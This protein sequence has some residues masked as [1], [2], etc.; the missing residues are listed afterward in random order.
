MP[1][2]YYATA[3]AYYARIYA[4]C[5]GVPIMY[6]GIIAACLCM[7]LEYTGAI[8]IAIALVYSKAHTACRWRGLTN[9]TLIEPLCSISY[10]ANHPIS[11]DIGWLDEQTGHKFMIMAA[12]YTIYNKFLIGWVAVQYHC[13]LDSSCLY[14]AR[15]SDS[16]KYRTDSS[17]IQ[18]NKIS[19]P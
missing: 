12:W 4:Q 3:G 18:S 8:T 13:T 16:L 10:K 11:S 15:P 2:P 19:M 14:L 6:A 1:R 17:N 9:C 7:V 5:F